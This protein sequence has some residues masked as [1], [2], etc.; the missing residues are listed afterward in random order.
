MKNKL[1][2]GVALCL[3]LFSMASAQFGGP[4]GRNNGQT[5]TEEPA[6]GP[7][8]TGAEAVEPTNPTRPGG[9]NG[10]STSRQTSNTVTIRFMTPWTN[11]SAIMHAGNAT[12]SMKLVK[13]YCG[14][15]ESKV[16]APGEGQS[17][18]IYFTQTL[19]GTP[20]GAG[21]LNNTDPISLDSILA[22]GATTVWIKPVPFPNGTPTLYSDFPPAPWAFA[23]R[24]SPSWCSTGITVKM[25]MEASGHQQELIETPQSQQ[26][27]RMAMAPRT[28]TQPSAPSTPLAMTLVPVAAVAVPPAWSNPFSAR[29]E[30][31]FVPPCSPKAAS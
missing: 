26:Q 8:D 21:G 13:N 16:P 12:D 25:A 9:G 1:L 11:S 14:W 7:G 18:Q 4:G 31:R 28:R 20:Y 2:F 6:A 17:A 10:G 29:T 3:G 30:S 15:F 24:S 5:T 27:Q 19:G 22:A 23:P